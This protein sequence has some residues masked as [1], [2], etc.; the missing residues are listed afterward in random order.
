M[1]NILEQMQKLVDTHVKGYQK[2]FE[3]DKHFYLNVLEEG[4]QVIWQV[5]DYGTQLFYNPFYIAQYRL[6]KSMDWLLLIQKTTLDYYRYYADNADDIG[7]KCQYFKIVKGKSIEPIT[8]RKEIEF[9]IIS[10]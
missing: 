1:D 5:R 6:R 2:D 8:D 4:E 7:Q 3:I 9:F 10:H